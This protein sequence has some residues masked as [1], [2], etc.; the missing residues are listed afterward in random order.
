MIKTLGMISA[1]AMPFFDI[2]LM[3]RIVQRKSS[4]DISLIWVIGAWFCVMGMLPQSLHSADPALRA[5]GIVNGIL[6]T[7]VFATVLYFHPAINRTR[8]LPAAGRT[9]LAG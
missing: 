2:P 4:A 9:D 7:G 3:A 1:I 8:R 5:F 6:F